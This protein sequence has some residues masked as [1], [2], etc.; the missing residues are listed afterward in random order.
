MRKLNIH[1]TL[2]QNVV[3]YCR[4]MNRTVRKLTESVI[5]FEANPPMSPHISLIMGI[6]DEKYDLDALI[7][8]VRTQCARFRPLTFRVLRPYLENIRNHYVF[9]DVVGD[10][11]FVVLKQTLHTALSGTYLHTKSDYSEA[12]HITLAHIEAK[13]TEVREYLSNVIADLECVCDSIE[14]SDVGPKGSCINSLFCLPL[15]RT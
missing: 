2:S 6:L 7:A 15:V 13:S 4:E 9:S 10:D 5:D 8:K 14:I 12:P 3:C 1:L 11:D